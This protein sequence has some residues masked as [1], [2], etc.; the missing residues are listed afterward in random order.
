MTSGRRE[1]G[2]EISKYPSL[3]SSHE[4]RRGAKQQGSTV[5]VYI[6]MHERQVDLGI[7][8]HLQNRVNKINYNNRVA[9]GSHK[10]ANSINACI[11]AYMYVGKC[12]II[13][14]FLFNSKPS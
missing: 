8:H 13:T 11:C 3:G 5:H 12:F 14:P 2:D 4:N 6:Y 1:P 7:I 10:S 9:W